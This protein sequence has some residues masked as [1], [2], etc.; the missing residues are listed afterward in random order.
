MM[1]DAAGAGKWRQPE[2]MTFRPRTE[3]DHAI[4][5]TGTWVATAWPLWGPRAKRQRV[6]VGEPTV[7]AGCLAAALGYA[8]ERG[9]HVFPVPPG[10]K[11]SCK[12]ADY[13]NGRNWGATNDPIEIRRDFERWP[14]AGVGIPTGEVNE[15][16]VLEADTLKGHGVD[17][18]AAMKALEEKHGRLPTT[19]M[20]ISPSGS[21][22]AYWRWPGNGTTIRN[23]ASEV[24]PGV[25]V[26]G[27]G[28]M[29]VAPP[30]VKPDSGVYRWLNDAPIADAPGWLLKAAVEAGSE[31]GERQS[32]EPQ[33]DAGRVAM[34]VAVIPNDELGWEEWNNTGLAIYR[35]TGG[36][37]EGLKVF[38]QW[39]RQSK[40]YD[41]EYTRDKWSKYH[42]CPP[43]NIGAGS[44]FFWASEACPEWDVAVA[45]NPRSKWGMRIAKFLEAVGIAPTE[46]P[47]IKVVDG[48]ISRVV[49]E[50]EAALL[51]AG[52]PLM[53]RAGMLV[54]PIKETFAAADDQKT[55]A[56][57]LRLLRP[58]SAVYMLNKYAATFVRFSER[59][60]RWVKTD[61]PE[62]VAATLLQKGAWAF[63]KVTGVVTAPTMRPD[64]T[65]LDCPG[66][67]PSTQLWYA[68]DSFLRVPPIKDRPT[69]GDAAAALELIESLLAGFPFVAD[70]D[71]CVALAAVLTPLLRAGC[72]VVPMFLFLAHAAGSGKSY[73]TDL[74]SVTAHGRRAPAISKAT[75]EEELEKR[76]GALVLAGVPVINIDNCTANL[77]GTTLCQVTERQVVRIR[78][79]GRSEMPECEYRGTVF[80][81]GNNITAEGD[82]TRRTLVSHID[83]GVERP[84]LRRFDFDPIE[85]VTR[86]RGAYVVAA[87]TI[88]RAYLA[89]G[90]RPGCDPIASYGRWSGV[91]R[92][93]L[94]WLG[95]EDPVKSMD[96]IRE[97]DPVRAAARA[98]YALWKERL[99]MDVAYTAA[100]VVDRANNARDGVDDLRRLLVMHAGGFRGEIDVK[101]AG[102]WLHSVYGQIHDGLR[103]EKVGGSRKKYA[104]K[105]VARK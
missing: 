94:I 88:A 16:W 41:S 3:A 48:Q 103:L 50:A 69:K 100:E 33:A 30:T 60:N 99:G 83:P 32:G 36:S 53:V 26:R 35:A 64:G 8:T 22:H 9:W 91:V 20:A 45:V 15:I 71:K 37:D 78:I 104:L 49:D 79:L 2:A 85:R 23:S 46:T 27:E 68:P 95:K 21:L 40:K 6:V 47:V 11:K 31:S 57:I 17:G 58:Q 70:L 42:T 1:T 84:E 82:L 90:E 5:S 13:S 96:E 66:H 54:H 44:I 87:L 19:L 92:E 101:R 76:L 29:V 39:S 12:K 77:S 24:A 65:I 55:E 52:V 56:T 72:D 59:K 86:D 89:S 10:T 105:A 61:P 75:T 62:R 38:D 67:D 63:P 14:E 7:A 80:A 25:D 43:D 93:P 74:I 97:E 102:M 34:A 98:L 73:L 4:L 28:G 81:N 18:I 51:K